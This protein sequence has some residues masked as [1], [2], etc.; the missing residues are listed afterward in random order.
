M[1]CYAGIGWS[2]DVGSGSNNSLNSLG[3]CQFHSGQRDWGSKCGWIQVDAGPEMSTR[4][5]MVPHI[6]KAEIKF[7][8]VWMN[9]RIGG[10][11]YATKKIISRDPCKK[12]HICQFKQNENGV[13]LYLR[14]CR[15]FGTPVAWR[16]WTRPFPST[17]PCVVNYSIASQCTRLSLQVELSLSVYILQM[18]PRPAFRQCQLQTR[19]IHASRASVCR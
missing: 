2:K 14:P 18:V 19:D 6:S 5:E 1:E 10:G 12:K 13:R 9:E 8:E 17:S 15:R 7:N 4:Q 11:N 16:I 3:W